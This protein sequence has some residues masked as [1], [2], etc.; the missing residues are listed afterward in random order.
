MKR[1][2]LMFIVYVAAIASI[3]TYIVT[4]TNVRDRVEALFSDDGWEVLTCDQLTFEYNIGELVRRLDAACD[5]VL[6][7]AFINPVLSAE[8]HRQ[9]RVFSGDW[10]LVFTFSELCGVTR[11]MSIMVGGINQEGRLHTTTLIWHPDQA[12]VCVEEE[13]ENFL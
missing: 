1:S 7:A 12:M 6:Y 13:Q 5:G 8:Y 11:P 2:K 9:D 3:S 10:N 4:N